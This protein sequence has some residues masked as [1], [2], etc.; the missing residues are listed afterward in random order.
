[1]D[2]LSSSVSTLK[3]PALYSAPREFYHFKTLSTSHQLPPH[4]TTKHNSISNKTTVQ[5]FYLKTLNSPQSCTSQSSSLKSSPNIHLN[6]ASGYA[7]ALLDVAQCNNSLETVQRDVERLLKLLQSE[8][9][10]AV[11]ANPL[12][13]EKNKGQLVNELAKKGK[14]NRLLVRLLKM[15]IERNKVI[16]VIEVLME[17]Q[18]IYDELSGTK[19]VLVSSQKKMEDDELFGIARSVLKLSGA[20]KVRVKNLFGVNGEKLPSF[21]M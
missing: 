6:P 14:M 1:M 18:R 7:A 11:L 4:L 3:V 13:G 10:Q 21:A 12:V 16:M 8:Q 15:L 20:M 19:V 17:F 2:T 5:S 9:A